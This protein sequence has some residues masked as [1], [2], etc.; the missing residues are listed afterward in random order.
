ME[1]RRAVGNQI[2]HCCRNCYQWPHTSFNI[3]RFEKLPPSFKLCDECLTLQQLSRCVEDPQE[4]RDL[5]RLTR[6]ELNKG[7]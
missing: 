2:W 4:A 5:R 6:P 1:Y 3:V 7:D